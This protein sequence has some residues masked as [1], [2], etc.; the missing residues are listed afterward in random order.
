M[1]H[2]RLHNLDYFAG[3]PNC[4]RQAA[5][6]KLALAGVFSDRKPSS[7]N[8]GVTTAM[9]GIHDSI[10]CDAANGQPCEQCRYADKREKYEAL[11]AVAKQAVV[12]RVR[13]ELTDGEPLIGVH[14]IGPLT[15][16]TS[17]DAAWSTAPRSMTAYVERDVAEFWHQTGQRDEKAAMTSTYNA[18]LREL[19]RLVEGKVG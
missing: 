1:R 5:L 6:K 13:A 16:G 12:E 11:L 17:F 4:E 10:T 3:C 19:R 18:D 14:H 2:C 9:S 15:T 8:G 7:E